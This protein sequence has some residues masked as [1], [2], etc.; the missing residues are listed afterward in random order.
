MKIFKL[1]VIVFQ[2]FLSLMCITILIEMGMV[3]PY[4]IGFGLIIATIMDAGQSIIYQ[5][6]ENHRQLLRRM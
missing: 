1:F 3:V 2:L 6:H 5:L 4:A